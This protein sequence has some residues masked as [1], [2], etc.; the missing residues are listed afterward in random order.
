MRYLQT[1]LTILSYLQIKYSTYTSSAYL[2]SSPGPVIPNDMD[3]VRISYLMRIG[4]PCGEV[5]IEMSLRKR[6]LGK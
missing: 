1:H 2:P 6:N 3:I 5:V 4:E